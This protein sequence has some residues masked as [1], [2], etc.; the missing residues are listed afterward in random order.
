MSSPR[1]SADHEWRTFELPL[2][3]SGT[4]AAAMLML[5]MGKSVGTIWIDDIKLQEGDRN[6]YRRDYEGGIALVNATDSAVTVNLNGT[7]RKIKGTQAPL[8]NDGS[9]VTSVTLPPKDG[10]VLL[11]EAPTPVTEPIA[12]ADSY[13]IEQRHRADRLG[14]RAAGQRYRS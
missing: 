11:R 6:V 7:F 3:S 8:V 2:T 12:N 5:N 14:T 4:A 10:L 13:A 1:D 9:L